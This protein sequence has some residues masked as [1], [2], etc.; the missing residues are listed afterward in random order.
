TVAGTSRFKVDYSVLKNDGS[1]L[2]W[3]PVQ[4]AHGLSYETAPFVD[5]VEITGHP[6]V[7][8]RVASTA[9]DGDFFAYLEEVGIDGKAVVRSH[10]RLRASHRKLGTAPFDTLG[11]PWHRSF[12]EDYTPLEPGQPVSLEFDM[13]PTSTIVKKGMKL[14][15]VIAGADPRQRMDPPSGPAPIVTIMSGGVQASTLLLP[16]VEAP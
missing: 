15:L 12:R 9:T 14:R 16:V 6:V 4:D 5:D 1:T 8:L 2:G 3:L 13:L 7:K 10:G 11:L